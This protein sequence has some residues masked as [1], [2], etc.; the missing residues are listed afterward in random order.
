MCSKNCPESSK[1]TYL[2]I[3]QLKI[4]LFTVNKQ[5]GLKTLKWKEG[6]TKDNMNY[7]K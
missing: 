6:L 7:D 1:Q 4:Y 2:N 5:N 3:H